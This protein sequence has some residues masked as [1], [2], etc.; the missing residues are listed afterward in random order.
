MSPTRPDDPCA[1]VQD[2]LAVL[3]MGGITGHDRARALAHLEGCPRCTARLDELSSTVDAL[4]MLIPEADPPEGFADRT[5]ALFRAEKAAQR[6]WARRVVAAAAVV[7]T[8]AVGAGVG[9]VVA[10][11]GSPP[12]AAVRTAPLHS[13]QGAE[14][15]AILASTGDQGWLS[16]TVRD[17]PTSGTVTCSIRLTDGSRRDVGRFSLVDGYGSWTATL[18]VGA[19]SVRAVDIT[20]GGGVTVAVAR[21]T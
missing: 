18:P 2:D 17:A 7:V 13:T 19:S 16:M 3:A 11:Q 4:T 21:W 1:A 20:D 14:G 5:V 6:P 10:L 12:A 15:T 9:E 8:L